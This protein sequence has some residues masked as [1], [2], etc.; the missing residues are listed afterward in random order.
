[1]RVI[2]WGGVCFTPAE[3]DMENSLIWGSLEPRR[4]IGMRDVAYLYRNTPPLRTCYRA[5]FGRSRSN[6]VGV[7]RSREF[8]KFSARRDSAALGKGAWPT[9]EICPCRRAL[10]CR[11]WSHGT[12]LC[13]ETHCKIGHSCP[14]FQC[15]S[16]SSEPTSTDRH[17]K[18][19][20][21]VIR[22]RGPISQIFPPIVYLK[23]L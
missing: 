3:I 14:V 17:P 22:N 8:Q 18:D 5:E 11:I 19:F 20:Q 23:P 2:A 6:R 15:H 1:M 21:S 10:L 4:P 16:R 12:S 7:S 13:A 9:R